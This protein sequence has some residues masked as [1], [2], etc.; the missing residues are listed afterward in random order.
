MSIIQSSEA[1][2]HKTELSNGQKSAVNAGHPFTFDSKSYA[3]AKKVFSVDA[4]I[5]NGSSDVASSTKSTHEN[6]TS[7][8][9]LGVLHKEILALYD[10]SAKIPRTNVADEKPAFSIASTT[11]P[12]GMGIFGS[13][14]DSVKPS[15]SFNLADKPTEPAEPGKSTYRE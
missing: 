4:S 10:T 11:G 12:I 13:K 6:T 7:P 14:V 2:H 15:F 1:S 3:T 9:N 5:T 8:K